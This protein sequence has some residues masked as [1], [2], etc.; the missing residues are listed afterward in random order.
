MTDAPLLAHDD[1]ID[2][3][4]VDEANEKGS[5]LSWARFEENADIDSPVQDDSRVNDSHF[6]EKK[7]KQESSHKPD[8]KEDQIDKLQ[9]ILSRRRSTVEDETRPQNTSSSTKRQNHAASRRSTLKGTRLDSSSRANDQSTRRG[10]RSQDLD[11]DEFNREE[12]CD[13]S[14]QTIGSSGSARSNR[15]RRGGRRAPPKRMQS[16]QASRSSLPKGDM[17]SLPRRV[18]SN[19]SSNSSLQRATELASLCQ[20]ARQE[21][22]KAIA[23]SRSRLCNGRGVFDGET[24]LCDVFDTPATIRNNKDSSHNNLSCSSKSKLG[25]EILANMSGLTV[26][27]GDSSSKCTLPSIASTFVSGA[28]SSVV[29]DTKGDAKRLWG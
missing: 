1:I 7:G 11:I 15:E 10:R 12:N 23:T 8:W 24:S 19:D 26:A 28:S 5:G 25:I 22:D 17:E 29:H 20:A 9:D 16:S 2:F 14:H 21:A 27:S 6:P 13:N 3:W 18:K 4:E